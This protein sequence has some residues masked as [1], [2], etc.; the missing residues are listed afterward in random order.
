M[1]NLNFGTDAPIYK[2]E[3]DSQ[4]TSHGYGEGGGLGV[5]GWQIKTIIVLYI[6]IYMA[7]YRMADQQAPT[8]V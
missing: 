6:H 1:W 3:T 7:I 2:M 5:W 4:R 8:N